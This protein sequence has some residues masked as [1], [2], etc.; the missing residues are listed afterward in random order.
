MPRHIAFLRAL[1]VGGRTVTMD[2]LASI[3]R[4]TGA[5]DVSTFLASGNVVFTTTKRSE[6]A[7]RT[8]LAS[9]LAQALG[10]EVATFLRTPAELRAILARPELARGRAGA[11]AT[12]IALLEEPL[13]AAAA[14][15]VLALANDTDRFALVGRELFWF[16][17]CK[18][19][20]SDFCNTVFE[21]TAGVSST[22][23]S[24]N[25]LERL[26]AKLVDDESDGR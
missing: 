20:D 9:A 11:V 16:C 12:N 26:A 6:T 22:F 21:K 7:V 24:V 23:R 10:Y 3:V 18:Q 5:T 17:A 15:R 19:S 4:S 25:T 8:A 13:A 2:R 1:N 14:K